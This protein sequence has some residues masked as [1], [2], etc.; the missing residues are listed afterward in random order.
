MLRVLILLTMLLLTSCAQTLTL[1]VDCIVRTYSGVTPE[2]IMV[3]KTWINCPSDE[4][5]EEGSTEPIPEG[6]ML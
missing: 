5:E 1:E 3:T 2:N 4:M 6:T